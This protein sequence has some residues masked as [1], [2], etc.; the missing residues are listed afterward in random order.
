[1]TVGADPADAVSAASAG[2]IPASYRA[3]LRTEQIKGARIGVG[4][5][6]FGPAPE[7]TEVA[8]VVNRALDALK[9]A[10]ADVNDVVV[11]GL[12]D[13]LRDSSMT[14]FDFKF[15]LPRYLSR[16]ENPPVKSLGE[17]LD[18]GMYHSALESTF[19]LRNAVESRDGDG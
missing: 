1:A 12:D 15:G 11:P 10:G 3:G 7:D 2:H 14:P 18:R 13:L 9:K 16:A 6:L 5:S 8:T 17:I 19:R 4:R